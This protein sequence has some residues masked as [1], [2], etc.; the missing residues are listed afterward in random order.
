M[1]DNRRCVKEYRQVKQDC[2]Y[3]SGRERD[4]PLNGYYHFTCN[5]LKHISDKED[6]CSLSGQLSYDCLEAFDK[7]TMACGP[8]TDTV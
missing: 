5:E 1:E 2:A 3:H 6:T 4:P 8:K 7:T